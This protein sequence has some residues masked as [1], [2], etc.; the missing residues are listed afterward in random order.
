[1]DPLQRDLLTLKNASPAKVRKIDGRFPLPLPTPAK[2][3]IQAQRQVREVPREDTAMSGP[4]AGPSAAAPPIESPASPLASRTPTVQLP[5]L[6]QVLV[7]TSAE[8][9]ITD[10]PLQSTSRLPP[11]VLQSSPKSLEPD[12]SI[13][14]NPANV[15]LMSRNRLEQE[16]EEL[17]AM[18]QCAW[19]TVKRERAIYEGA[20]AQLVLQDTHLE[21]LNEQLAAKEVK[22]AN[23]LKKL[24]AS[25]MARCMTD[26]IK[27]D[28]KKQKEDAAKRRIEAEA[29]QVCAAER[30]KWREAEKVERA[31]KQKAAIAKWEQEAQEAKRLKRKQ[32]K[33][34]AVTKLYPRAPTPDH[35]KP[36]KQREAIAA[37]RREQEEQE[38]QEE[39]DIKGAGESG[40]DRDSESSE[41]G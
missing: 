33:R 19:E 30:E 5:L 6:R 39:I 25:K 8:F 14:R 20:N 17:R 11:L 9:L 29:E 4:A 3:I 35:L 21:E 1:I 22:E 41:S 34:P 28:L 32:P 18:L 31:S 24:M 2:A 36:R 40:S 13:L 27:R 38:E 7:G 10:S 23:P 15:A 16:V 12:W 26:N 37:N